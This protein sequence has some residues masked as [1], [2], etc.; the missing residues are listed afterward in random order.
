MSVWEP[1]LSIRGNVRK[2]SVNSTGR[3]KLSGDQIAVS[4]HTAGEYASLS[5]ELEILNRYGIGYPYL[6]AAQNLARKHKTGAIDIL[7]KAGIISHSIWLDAQGLLQKE[8]RIKQRQALRQE[9]LLTQATQNLI[10]NTP[11][12]SA[13]LTITFAQSICIFLLIVLSIP[14]FMFLPTVT[15][16]GVYLLFAAF[17]LASIVL[18][19]FLLAA[20]EKRLCQTTKIAERRPDH[21][22]PFYSVLV[23]LYQESG[24]ISDLI[25]HLSLLDW[26]KE[27]LDIKLICEADDLE[28]ISAI[29]AINMPD[30]FELVLVPYSLPRTK[31]KALN[32]ALPLCRGEYTVL[33]DAEDRPSR[34]QLREAYQA[35]LSGEL[36]LAC[37]QAP[38]R[39][40][41]DDQNW[42][43]R[44]FSIEYITLFNGILP[45]LAKWRVPLPLG[46]TSNHFK[47]CI[48]K[49]V[50]GW[51]PYNVTEDADLG[52]RL[53]REGYLCS[54]IQEPT[55][56]EA[57]PK[58]GPWITQRT[59]WLKGWMQTILVHNR[60]PAHL[61]SDIGLKNTLVFHLLLTS[62]VLSVLIHPWFLV[63]AI[64]Q[65]SGLTG[66]ISN[67]TDFAIMAGSVFNLVGGYTTYGLL[68]FAVLK[69]L[70]KDKY[71]YALCSLPVYW[72]LI[73]FAGWRALIHLIVKPHKWEKTP[74]GLANQ[75]FKPK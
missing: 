73:S 38:L 35:F 55:Y 21:S 18:R 47:T 53:F 24:Q 69:T 40:H 49:Q 15:I 13:K 36:K 60:N 8:N 65:L 27:K 57:P 44:M 22:M 66:G 64:V 56:E 17:Y 29:Q 39:I 28:T 59:R 62:V 32:Y 61:V 74:H 72:I 45:V 67:G 54:T 20:F 63:L 31:P 50:G 1:P 5:P 46:G 14:G 3:G 68:A 19:G 58:L 34:G 51:D 2:V 10:E 16:Y 7:F 12:Y 11:H 37:L 9:H 75:N 71:I 52:I 42:L 41:N 25:K 33:Y 26:P 23:A 70:K 48:L 43:A 6:Y 30:Y 4:S